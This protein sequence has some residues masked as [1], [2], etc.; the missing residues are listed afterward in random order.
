MWF[1]VR[2]GD[3]GTEALILPMVMQSGRPGS[4]K[5][6]ANEVG[7]TELF[8]TPACILGSVLGILSLH[9]NRIWVW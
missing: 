6:V 2:V 8:S 5:V 1:E 4:S 3:L 9:I 7:R